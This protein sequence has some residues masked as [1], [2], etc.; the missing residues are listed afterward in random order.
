MQ[1]DPFWQ[2][3]ASRPILAKDGDGRG[4]FVDVVLFYVSFIGRYCVEQLWKQLEPFWSGLSVTRLPDNVLFI[5]R[6]Y[7]KVIAKYIT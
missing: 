4:L 5:V 7:L 1:L 6:T 2:A 3:V